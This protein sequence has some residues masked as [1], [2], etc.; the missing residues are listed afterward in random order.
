MKKKNSILLFT[1]F[2]RFTGEAPKTHTQ[3]PTTQS[4]RGTSTPTLGFAGQYAKLESL[5][6]THAHWRNPGGSPTN[7]PPSDT[8]SPV[9]LSGRP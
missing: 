2:G 7:P 1:I 8:L 3:R 6:E 5:Q 9:D 4:R